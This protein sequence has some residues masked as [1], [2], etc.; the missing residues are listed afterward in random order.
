MG[1]RHLTLVQHNNEMKV[2]QY[3]QWDG[4]PKGQ[5]KTVLEFLHKANMDKFKKQLA[6]VRFTTNVEKDKK[7]TAP[8]CPGYEPEITFVKDFGKYA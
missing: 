5:G 8:V 3:G 4:Y 2:A 6:K 1:T 7:I